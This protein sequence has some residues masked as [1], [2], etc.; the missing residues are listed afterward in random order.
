LHRVEYLHVPLRQLE[1]FQ[2]NMLNMRPCAIPDVFWEPPLSKLVRPFELDDELLDHIK[3]R[4]ASVVCS[5]EEPVMFEDY[6]VK[7]FMVGASALARRERLINFTFCSDKADVQSVGTKASAADIIHYFFEEGMDHIEQ[8][9][10]GILKPYSFRDD[11]IDVWGCPDGF[12]Q[13]LAPDG[14]GESRI[15]VL[16]LKTFAS[17]RFLTHKKI[18]EDLRQMAAYQLC[19]PNYQ[20]FVLVY[21]NTHPGPFASALSY[22]A[23]RVS[24]D[25]NLR[26]AY[27]AWRQWFSAFGTAGWRRHLPRI[28]KE[29]YASEHLT[30]AQIRSAYSI[31]PTAAAGPKPE[32]ARRHENKAGAKAAKTTIVL[33]GRFDQLYDDNTES[34]DSD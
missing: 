4:V 8:N 33:G 14:D 13:R 25:E 7:P 23:L 30:P 2:N 21:I 9:S 16:E 17:L 12:W 28:L 1:K 26:F 5:E 15:F 24:V 20:D 29:Y 19:W 27:T 31:S 18:S 10:A 3:E 34:S 11:T 22:F 6:A 32:V